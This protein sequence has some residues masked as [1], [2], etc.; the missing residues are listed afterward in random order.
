MKKKKKPPQPIPCSLIRKSILNQVYHS[1]LP[2]KE[3]KTKNGKKRLD[4]F[5]KYDH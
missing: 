4:S 2:P 3:L 5:K 1:Y